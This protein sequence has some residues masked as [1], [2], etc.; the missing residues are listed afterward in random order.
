MSKPPLLAVQNLSVAFRMKEKQLKAV[1]DVS[2]QIYEKEMLGIVGESGCGKTCTAKA[3]VKLLPPHSTIISG[4]VLYQGKNLLDL[5]EEE[6]Q[7]IR[8]REIGMIFQDPMTSLNPTMKI[9]HQILEGYLLHHKKGRGK[10]S[11]NYAIQLLELVGIPQPD[12]RIHEYPHT[13][14]GGMRQ[15]VMIALA[16]APQPKLIIAD[17]PTTALDVTIQA[18]IL[19]L[20]QQ[21]KEKMGT[22]FL[23]I[24][25]DMSV[26]AGYCDRVLV[27][28]GGKIIEKAYV[29]Q[30]FTQPS[31]P[32]TQGLLKSI[33][34]LDMSKETPL[35]PIDGAPPSLIDP[36]PGCSFCPRC[37]EALPVCQVETPL[38]KEQTAGHL[39]A[40]WKRE[41]ER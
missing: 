22:S 28:Y 17:E 13:L 30:L 31:H 12:R 8:G 39:V 3:L 10:E 5:T 11:L 7:K 6:I 35:I 9:G 14:S 1:R 38:L 18:Q 15:R 36:L 16:L 23:F 25:H 34:R 41:E 26:V 24:T 21:I 4:D 33:P 29:D 2:F 20:L 27:M 37:Q 32:Y 19:E 40:C